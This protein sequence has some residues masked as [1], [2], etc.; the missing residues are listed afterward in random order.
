MSALK[1]GSWIRQEKRLAIYLRD[2]FLCVYCLR[3]LH[4]ADPFDITLDHIKTRSNGGHNDANNLITA[5]RSC[6]SARQDQP[7]HRFTGPE[8][9]KHIK[10][11]TKRSLKKYKVL[12]KSLIEEK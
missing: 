1:S 6:N 12:A 9:I 11:N 8:T 4:D 3:D 10:R 2:R 7:L 5:C